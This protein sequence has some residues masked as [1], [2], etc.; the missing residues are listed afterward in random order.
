MHA[1]Q[2]VPS[3]RN[4]LVRFSGISVTVI[5]FT[6]ESVKSVTHWIFSDS[7]RNHISFRH[8]KG[9]TKFIIV[10]AAI[11]AITCQL[12]AFQ[13]DA[14]NFQ[15]SNKMRSSWTRPNETRPR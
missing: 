1:S 12:D 10:Q 3:L 15:R 4:L 13:M 2:P 8:Q 11:H 5:H 9:L 14:V 7:D 6:F